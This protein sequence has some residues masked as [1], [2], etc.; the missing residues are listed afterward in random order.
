MD[1]LTQSNFTPFC[2]VKLIEMYNYI[3]SFNFLENTSL[4]FEI[5]NRQEI[6]SRIPKINFHENTLRAY[7]KQLKERYESMK[8]NTTVPHTNP[9][10]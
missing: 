2:I 8:N 6:F 9:I 7:Y 1:F 4:I 10:P 3:L 5:Y